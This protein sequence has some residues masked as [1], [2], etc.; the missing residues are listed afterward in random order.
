VDIKAYL[1]AK[2]VHDRYRGSISLGTL[3]NWR[4]LRVGPNY[5]KIGKA[6]LYPLVELDAWDQRNKVKCRTLAAE[7]RYGRS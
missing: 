3:R 2:E 6:V 1:T 4:A 5:L 7:R